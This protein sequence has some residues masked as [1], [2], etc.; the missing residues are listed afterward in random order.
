MGN[1]WPIRDDQ[2]QEPRKRSVFSHAWP[3][4]I[5]LIKE[6]NVRARSK[7]EGAPQASELEALSIL[8]EE[9]G[10]VAMAINQNLPKK[11]LEKEIIQVAS[12]AVRWLMGDLTF[13]RRP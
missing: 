5:M 8:G 13:S 6:E 12:V 4:V 10:E 3:D 1:H 9:F 2:E 7:H 11:E